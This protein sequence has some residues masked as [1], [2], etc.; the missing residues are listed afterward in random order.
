M[1]DLT[2]APDGPATGDAKLQA[3]LNFLRNIPDRNGAPKKVFI[4]NSESDADLPQQRHRPGLDTA[5]MLASRI[6]DQSH[7]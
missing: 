5:F 6:Q 2:L 7:P 3:T 1:D 4:F